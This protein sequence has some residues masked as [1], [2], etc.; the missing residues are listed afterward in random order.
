M[1]DPFRMMEEIE[2][3][4]KSAFDFDDGHESSFFGNRFPQGISHG[5]NRNDKEHNDDYFSQ[6]E[7]E[8]FGGGGLFGGLSGMSPDGHNSGSSFS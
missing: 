7:K 6:I 3:Q 5:F 2:R 1:N 8:F 4:M